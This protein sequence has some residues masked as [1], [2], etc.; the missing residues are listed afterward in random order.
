MRVSK[1]GG[2]LRAAAQMW[3]EVESDE[4]VVSDGEEEEDGRGPAMRMDATRTR[5][6][7]ASSS[8]GDVQAML[9]LEL[10]KM[11]G[12]RRGRGSSDESNGNGSGGEAGVFEVKGMKGVTAMWKRFRQNPK[13]I[14]REYR[15]SAKLSLGVMDVRQVW[16]YRD[17]SRRLLKTFGKMRGLWRCQAGLQ[18]VVQL[19]ADA[20]MD[21]ALAYVCQ[22][23]KA[24]APGRAGQGL[25]GRGGLVAPGAGCAGR[26]SVRRRRTRIGRDPELQEGA[27]RVE[28]TT[29]QGL[30]RQWELGRGQRLAGLQE[31][32]EE[33]EEEGEDGHDGRRREGGR[34]CGEGEGKA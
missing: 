31:E 28:D 14:F 9:N 2:H 25:V 22:L 16:H 5:S 6:N 29:R 1:V 20:E 17:L 24:L 33:E 26:A 10:L 11:L 12:R 7:C 30:G 8:G 4:S 32:E 34:G 27:A 3:D 23:S 19:M 13:A 18:E 21:M 15:A